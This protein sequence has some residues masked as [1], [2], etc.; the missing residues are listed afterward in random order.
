[1]M[2]RRGIKK[3]GVHGII[4]LHPLMRQG[5]LPG[6]LNPARLLSYLPPRERAG[7]GELLGAGEPEDPEERL[8]PL[9]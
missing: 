2:K 7:V 3:V 6:N 9:S 8:L 5:E 1:M 4:Q